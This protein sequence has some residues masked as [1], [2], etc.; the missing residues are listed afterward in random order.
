[1][2][3]LQNELYMTVCIIIMYKEECLKN[4]EL[5]LVHVLYTT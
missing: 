3:V 4:W 5:E 1:M 2:C